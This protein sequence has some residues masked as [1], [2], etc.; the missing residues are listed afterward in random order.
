MSNKSVCALYSATPQGKASVRY[1]DTVI[2][3][4][5][6]VRWLV[7]G[8]PHNFSLEI[9]MRYPRLASLLVMVM[10]GFVA[11]FVTP[12]FSEPKAFSRDVLGMLQLLTILLFYFIAYSGLFGIVVSFGVEQGEAPGSFRTRENILGKLLDRIDGGGKKKSGE[13]GDLGLGYCE[14]SMLAGLAI[15]FAT[16]VLF[17]L[18]L[19]AYIGFTN[20]GML[21]NIGMGIGLL[22]G[23]ALPYVLSSLL[24]GRVAEHSPRLAC[25]LVLLILGGT[26]ASLYIFAP[27]MQGEMDWETLGR[28]SGTVAL[29]AAGVIALFGLRA[30]L[31][32]TSFYSRFCPLRE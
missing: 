20:F 31:K 29:F 13:S 5:H 22:L 4:I 7:Y 19:V 14:F 27:P 11:Y 28:V 18:V 30:L 3:T 26:F 25:F 12:D 21:L 6:W 10:A 16:A 32:K 23:V 17:V 15:L 2:D 8:V 1:N 24:I 9:L